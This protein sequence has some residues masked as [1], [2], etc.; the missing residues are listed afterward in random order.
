MYRSIS[1]AIALLPAIAA[2]PAQKPS[3][4][5]SA[6]VKLWVD[7]SS[8]NPCEQSTPASGDWMIRNNEGRN[9]LVT[10]HRTTT[11]DG[12]TKEDQIRDTLGPRESRELGCEISEDG[13]QTLTLVKAI[14]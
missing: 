11:K 3:P 8:G 10:V 7:T 9:V 6:S 12:A 1:A 4:H 13:Q 2:Y 5:A 14:F